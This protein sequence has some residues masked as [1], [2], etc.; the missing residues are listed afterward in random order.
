MQ[1]GRVPA[2]EPNPSWICNQ[3]QLTIMDIGNL[4]YGMENKSWVR[5]SEQ[6]ES[7][8]AVTSSLHRRTGE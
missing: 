1:A 7:G 2:R 3:R 5:E 4:I 8:Q 6:I